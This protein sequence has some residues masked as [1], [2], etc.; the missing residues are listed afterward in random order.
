MLCRR[1][2]CEHVNGA[3]RRLTERHRVCS[4]MREDLRSLLDSPLLAKL[5]I[6]CSS[7]AQ[8][9]RLDNSFMMSMHS[10]LD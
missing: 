4:H 6:P 9:T 10:A 5:W 8:A 2:L 7:D 1:A 3:C